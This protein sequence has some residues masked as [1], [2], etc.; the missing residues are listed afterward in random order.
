MKSTEKIFGGAGY[1]PQFDRTRLTLQVERIR[2]FMFRV[3]W[4]TLREIKAALEDIYAPAV[5]PESSISAQLR[6]LKK[7]PYFYRLLKRRRAGVHGPGAGIWEYRL[8]PRPQLELFVEKQGEQPLAAARVDAGSGRDDAKG[9]EE[10]FREARH[11]ATEAS[12]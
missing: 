10:F 1:D 5:F 11:I 2:I 4:R 3:E 8:L 12:K 7:P 6:N 9:R